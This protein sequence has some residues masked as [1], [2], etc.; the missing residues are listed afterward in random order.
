MES[1]PKQACEGMSTQRK[2]SR[3]SELILA[4]ASDT[5]PPP[6]ASDDLSLGP[7][8]EGMIRDSLTIEIEDAKQSGMLGYMSRSL[9]QATLPHTDPKCSH[10][11]RTSGI[12]TLSITG[13]PSVGIPYGSLPRTLLAWICSEAVRTKSRELDLGRS[14]TEFLQ[15]MGLG[16][17]GSYTRPLKDQAHR[18]FSSLIT[19]T[20]SNDSNVGLGNTVI[21]KNARLFWNARNPDERSLWDSVL[22]LTAD[23]FEDVTTAPVPIDLR[24]LHQLKKSPLSMD[25]YTWACYRQFLMKAKGQGIV[26]IPWAALQAQFGSG[27]GHS[28]D[29]LARLEGVKERQ[30]K[31]KQ[32]LWNFKHNFVKRLNEVGIFYPELI[33]GISDCSKFLTMKSVKLHVPPQFIGQSV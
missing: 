23:F 25:I 19:V 4:S 17:G 26:R 32:A 7:R 29:A 8:I 24:V 18:L 2:T 20:S 10:Y 27:Y 9:V 3:G 21:A 30:A 28:H 1:S 14:Q 6:Q 16:T 15:K 12:V 33:E 31:E 13:R 22:T 11:E 5:E